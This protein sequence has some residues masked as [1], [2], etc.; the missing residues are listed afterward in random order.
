MI[1]R[2]EITR[3]AEKQLR[4]LPRHIVDNL[5]IWVTAVELDGLE[6][7][8][9]VPGYHDEKLKGDRAGQRSIRL[10]RG[11]RAIYEVKKDTARFVSVEE[12][13]KHDY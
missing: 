10:S 9:R 3:R 5:T 4:K 8:R 12:V 7:V 11:Y 13:S 6:E 2:V 1:R